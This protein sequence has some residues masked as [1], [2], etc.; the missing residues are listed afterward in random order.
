MSLP[1]KYAWVLLNRLMIY[2]AVMSTSDN[3][4][5]WPLALFI[6]KG[7]ILLVGSFLDFET[8]KVKNKSLNNSRFVATSVYEVVI[9]YTNRLFT[10]TV[11][12]HTIWNY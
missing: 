10:G 5:S 7:L 2:H 1:F 6:Y 12:Y 11:S 9:V 8:C 3:S 4:P